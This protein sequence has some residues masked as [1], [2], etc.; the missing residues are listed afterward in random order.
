MGS[1]N[2]DRYTR[3]LDNP[4]LPKEANK[5][6]C[7]AVACFVVCVPAGASH[8]AATTRVQPAPASAPAPP[9]PPPPPPPPL[10]PPPLPPPPPPPMLRSAPVRRQVLLLARQL[11]AS[12][13]PLWS[14]LRAHGATRL[15]RLGSP[16]LLL[17]PQTPGGRVLH[18]HG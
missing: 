11:P 6:K 18:V 17:R 3:R 16:D 10:P 2:P 12:D 8:K 14:A 4:N 1:D 15:H 13:S 5:A 7:I 9:P